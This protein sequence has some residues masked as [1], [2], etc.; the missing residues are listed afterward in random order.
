VPKAI[1]Q[2]PGLSPYPTAAS[3]DGFK[4]PTSRER[5]KKKKFS[6]LLLF[7][8]SNHKPTTIK[9]HVGLKKIESTKK[10]FG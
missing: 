10:K 2:N 5:K 9:F 8:F 3:F 7:L 1:R 4:G 6:F